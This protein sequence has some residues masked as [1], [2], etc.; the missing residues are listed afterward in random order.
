MEQSTVYQP[1]SF[2]MS[3]IIGLVL[4]CLFDI[5]KL[6][7]II[8]KRNKHTMLFDICFSVL[9][10]YFIFFALMRMNNGILRLYEFI[11]IAIGF[12]IYYYLCRKFFVFIL[13]LIIKF[14][15]RIG[16]IVLTPIIFIYKLLKPVIKKYQKNK[17]RLRN[18]AR[19]I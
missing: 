8:Y 13:I 12:I 5:F 11:G 10:L 9:A 17:I 3:I 14:F 1:L 15:Y 6:V 4:G 7:R 16:K 18:F 19:K 2:L